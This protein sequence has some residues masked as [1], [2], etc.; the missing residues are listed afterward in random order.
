[1][2]RRLVE[3]KSSGNNDHSS[4]PLFRVPCQPSAARPVFR[5]KGDAVLDVGPEAGSVFR[6]GAPRM[7]NCVRNHHYH[8]HLHLQRPSAERSTSLQ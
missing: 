2:I 1:M 3:A 7:E 5:V 4:S 8:P 6:L